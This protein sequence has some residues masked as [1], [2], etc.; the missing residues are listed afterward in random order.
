MH[1]LKVIESLN[2]NSSN[3]VYH[4]A[5]I[6]LFSGYDPLAPQTKLSVDSLPEQQHDKLFT[7]EFEEKIY[8]WHSERD[9]GK[10]RF[11]ELFE[12]LEKENPR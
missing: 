2:E 9:T 4:V 12:D 7:E 8:A 5:T 10:L 11:L 3:I 1:S 6:E